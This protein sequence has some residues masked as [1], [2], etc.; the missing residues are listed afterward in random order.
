[1]CFRETLRAALDDLAVLAPEWLVLQISPDWFER[2]PPSDRELSLTPSAE[3]QRTALAQQIGAYGVH[4]LPAR[5]QPEA[6]AELKEAPSVQVLR[7]VWQQYYDLSA[8]KARWRAGPQ[9]SGKEGIIRSPYDPEAQTGKKREVTWLG[10]I[11]ASDRN[12]CGGGE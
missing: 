6:A 9:A 11:R 2:V 8:G 10:D 12:V 7:Q 5:E 4:L 1:L 3:S